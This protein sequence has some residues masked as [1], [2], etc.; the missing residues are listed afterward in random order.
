MTIL[1]HAAQALLDA[2]IA[3]MGNPD[4]FPD[5][6]GTTSS[7]MSADG[8]K[9]DDG[10]IT[11][12]LMRQLRDALADTRRICRN[13][14]FYDPTKQVV[15]KFGSEHGLCRVAPPSP[16]QLEFPWPVINQHNWCG[17]F[18]RV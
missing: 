7:V 9:L 3:D 8:R 4:E 13:C 15:R 17:R 6:N 18:S 1:R 16:D 14:E 2:V 5:D 10:A 11:F 12:P